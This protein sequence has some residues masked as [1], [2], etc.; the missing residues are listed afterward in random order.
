MVIL[1]EAELL[2]NPVPIKPNP[3]LNM[4][5]AFVVGLMTAVGLAFLLEYLDQSIRTEQ[6]IEQYLGLP[7]IGAIAYM[8]ENDSAVNSRSKRIGGDNDGKK[9][10]AS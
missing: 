7:V 8:D 4:A 2:E 10:S 9:R 6:D 5:I 1:A 3:E